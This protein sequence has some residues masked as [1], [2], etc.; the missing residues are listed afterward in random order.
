[1]C[2]CVCV[3]VCVG[4]HFLCSLSSWLSEDSR[5]LRV[6][7][8]QRTLYASLPGRRGPLRLEFIQPEDH[9]DLRGVEGS[10][11]RG[12][13]RG[14]GIFLKGVCGE[15]A[16]CPSGPF[17]FLIAALWSLPPLGLSFSGS[18]SSLLQCRAPT[19]LFPPTSWAPPQ[20]L[21]LCPLALYS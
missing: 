5:I 6:R 2:V 7:K 14:S 8:W 11:S 17:C 20:S 4:A 13:A 3:C 21:A 19:W 10:L 9:P 18:A 15:G 12:T 1:V 16:G